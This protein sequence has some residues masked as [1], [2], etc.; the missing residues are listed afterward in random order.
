MRV[1][2]LLLALALPLCPGCFTLLG[3]ALDAATHGTGGARAGAGIDG[4]LLNSALQG[5]SSG[6]ATPPLDPA[7]TPG[8]VPYTYL[9]TVPGP[10]AGEDVEVIEARSLEGAIDVCAAFNDLGDAGSCVC[11]V[12]VEPPPAQ[13]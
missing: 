7:R 9:C 6:G 12:A 1:A 2:V 13:G 8:P 11:H 10:G 5:A 3:A 4:A